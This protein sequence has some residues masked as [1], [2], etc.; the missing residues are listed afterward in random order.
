MRSPRAR[1]R[2]CDTAWRWLGHEVTAA[3]ETDLHVDGGA[4]ASERL[5]SEEVGQGPVRGRGG[6]TAE[7]DTRSDNS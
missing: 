4:A 2:R 6:M 5:I 1:R 3:K 7:A